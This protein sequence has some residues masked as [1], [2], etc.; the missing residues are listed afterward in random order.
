LFVSKPGN[1]GDRSKERKGGG[2]RDKE[3]V[4]G[5][6]KLWTGREAVVIVRFR[7]VVADAGK[8][9]KEKEDE[10]GEAGLVCM[11]GLPKAGSF[12]CC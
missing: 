2:A 4:R 1:Q 9:K 12:C 8:P 5:V 11:V 7:R 6:K 3:I 10:V